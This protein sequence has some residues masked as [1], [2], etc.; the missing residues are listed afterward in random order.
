MYDCPRG[1]GANGAFNPVDWNEDPFDEVHFDDALWAYSIRAFEEWRN[2]DVNQ[3]MDPIVDRLM[4]MGCPDWVDP[5][6]R[7]ASSIQLMRF[8]TV[9]GSRLQQRI[10]RG[11]VEVIPALYSLD[12]FK[13]LI[14]LHR[15]TLGSVVTTRHWRQSGRRSPPSLVVWKGSSIKETL[16]RS[17]W[18]EFVGIW[19]QQC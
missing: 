12:L 1:G 14:F 8:A 18:L 3:W 19:R 4:L 2:R 10:I 9:W 13:V 5:D 6:N 17:K 11:E 15:L 16:R 7:T